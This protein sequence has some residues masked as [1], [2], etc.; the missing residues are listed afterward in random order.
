MSDENLKRWNLLQQKISEKRIVESFEIFRREGI[1]PILIKGWAAARNYPNPEQRSYTDIDL[2]VEEKNFERA[3]Q[4]KKRG[5]LFVDV[6]NELRHLDTLD[7]QKIYAESK[8]VK[9]GD[10]EVRIL[11]AEDHLRVLCV[12]WL[13]DGG[14]YRERLWDVYYAVAN[15]PADFNWDRCLKV[16][17]RTRRQ[18][19]ACTV[20]LAEK[21]LGLNTDETP[22]SAEAKNLPAWLIK[23]VEKEWQSEVKLK[24]LYTC[25]K[26]KREFFEQIKIRIPPNPI[27]ST[28]EMEGKFD[29]GKRI[30]YQIGAVYRLK[31]SIKRLFDAL[32]KNR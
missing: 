13:N 24:P 8:I 25:L 20:G 14:A 4:L 21:Y 30:R 5:N 12:H 3:E 2:A 11:R 1:E 17:S 31:P 26:N 32:W 19:I 9:I 6:H 29:D 23:T 16:V 15:R 28:I 22:F 10:T 7:W 18:W 27:Q